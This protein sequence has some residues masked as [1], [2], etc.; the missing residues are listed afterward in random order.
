MQAEPTEG[1]RRQAR[2]VALV[3]DENDPQVEPGGFR[4]PVRARRIE[5]P[6]ENVPVDHDRAGK[7]PVALALLGRPDIHDQ[8]SAGGFGSQICC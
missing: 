3:A 1:R 5:P 6:L 2:A 7:L 4:D 8:R